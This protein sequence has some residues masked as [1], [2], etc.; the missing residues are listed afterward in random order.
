MDEIVIR[1]IIYFLIIV[2]SIWVGNDASK[3]GMNA[4]GW[5]LFT[6]LLWIIGF[7]LFLILRGNNAYLSKVNNSEKNSSKRNNQQQEQP[8]QESKN[9]YPICEWCGKEIEGNKYYTDY[10]DSR[11]SGKKWCVSTYNNGVYYHQ[12]CAYQFCENKNK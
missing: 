6:L 1:V 12:N 3:R 11:E 8:S 5:G 4:W 9:Q 2:S 10:S 7:P